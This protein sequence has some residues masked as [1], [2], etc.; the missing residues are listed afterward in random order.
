MRDRDVSGEDVAKAVELGS[1]GVLVASGI[2]RAKN[3]DRAIS[4]FAR[5]MRPGTP[6]K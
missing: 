2:V 6:G 4:E 5:S 1:A 3:W